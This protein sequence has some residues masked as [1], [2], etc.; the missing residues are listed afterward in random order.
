MDGNDT[1][2]N[3]NQDPI[4]DWFRMWE[5]LDKIVRTSAKCESLECTRFTRFTSVTRYI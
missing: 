5:S 2:V 3:E 4:Y 1:N